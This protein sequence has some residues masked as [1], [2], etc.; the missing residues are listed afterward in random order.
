MV[1]VMKKFNLIFLFLFL[2]NSEAFSETVSQRL[3]KIEKRLGKIEQNLDSSKF[4]QGLMGVETELNSN[5]APAI[6]KLGFKINGLFCSDGNLFE[7]INVGYLITNNYEQEVKLIDAFFV[8]KDLFGDEVFKAKIARGVY[9]KPGKS[10]NIEG[11]VTEGLLGESCSKIKQSR[12]PDLTVELHVS[13]I[14]FGDNSILEFNKNANLEKLNQSTLENKDLFNP[15]N[16]VNLLK[17]SKGNMK[18]INTINN[19]SS[20]SAVDINVIKTQIYGC[21]SIPLGLPLNE[22]LVVKVKVK[23]RKDGSV[24]KT[25]LLNQDEFD[26]KGYYDIVADSALRAIKLCEPFKLPDTSYDIW[27]E[28]V[29][30]FEPKAALGG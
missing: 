21:W 7:K 22:D 30:N 10:K 25:Q 18:E 27:K 12:L 13:K 9:L 26:G 16:I 11:D 6:T 28:I 2:T 14:A 8:A 3:D 1:W 23:L 15:D 4:L 5:L 19:S 29:L 24:E 17:I 20:L